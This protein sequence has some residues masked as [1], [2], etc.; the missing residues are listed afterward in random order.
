MSSDRV[1]VL[2][3]GKGDSGVLLGTFIV[4]ALK[5]QVTSENTPSSLFDK[6]QQA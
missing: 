6:P 5:A 3:T 2:S 1:V 4:D